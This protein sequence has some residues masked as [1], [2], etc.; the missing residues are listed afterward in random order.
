MNQPE[1]TDSDR[2]IERFENLVHCALRSQVVAGR[3]RVRRIEA[4]G[5]SIVIPESHEDLGQLVEC[6]PDRRSTASRVFQQEPDAGRFRENACLAHATE[7]ADNSANPTIQAIADV[8][9]KMGDDR[10]KL[11]KPR[12]SDFLDQRLDGPFEQRLVGTRQ[13]QQVHRVGDDEL[14]RRTL[15]AV[16][17]RG[18]PI[19][20]DRL[21]PPRRCI[22]GE[23]LERVV[24]E[25]LGLVNRSDEPFCDRQMTTQKRT[26]ESQTAG[27]GPIIEPRPARGNPR[28]VD[29]SPTAR[30]RIGRRD[31]MSYD[32]VIIG[33]GPGGYVCAIRC[34]Q[35]GFKTA[36]VEEAD[37]GG[38]CLNWGCI[39]TKALFSAT[40]LLHQAKTA[41]EMGI[42]FGP[43]KIDL[44][45]LADW[46]ES[47]VSKLTTGVGMLLEKG[48]VDVMRARGRL[49]DSGGVAL[50]TGETVSASRT[51]L[52]TGSLP[53]EIPGFSFDQEAVWS[54]DDALALREI[55]DRLVVIGGGVI[56]LELATI[57]QRLGSAVTVIELLPE[58]LSAVD[59]DRRT[60]S[61]LKRS[62][63][64]QGIA[65]LTNTAAQGWEQTSNGINVRLAGGNIVEGDRILLAVGRRPNSID[66]GLDAAGVEIDP[67]GFVVV[68]ACFET[69]APSIF[70]IGDLV[71]GPML[72]HKASAEGVALAERF[73]GGSPEL[74]VDLIPQAIFTDP[75]I[76][77][78]GLSEARA[79][80]TERAILVGRFP[81]A[82]L[83]KALGM[84][85]GDGFFQIVAD[86][87]S[88]RVLGVQIVGAEASDLIS[89]AAVAI[90]NGLT[91]EALAETVHPHPTL[92][93]GLKEAAENALGRAIH[94]ANR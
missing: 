37:L 55:P 17:E 39:P 58:L 28:P 80:E 86:G 35:L 64:A 48:G 72:A 81:Y 84:R 85:A 65:T 90:R 29:G 20:R 57:Y 91:L 14:D 22:V 60:I 30:Y 77:S 88:H 2:T 74:D 18:G 26:P 43:A 8:R 21:H 4:H 11:Q 10:V 89:E 36:L 45:N 31:A 66:L 73:A 47:V 59:L 71:P 7:C 13:I 38:V 76:A 49:T 40:K 15:H 32:V 41:A 68:D 19:G 5:E 46:K 12:A 67:R 79:K 1:P 34:A 52:A 75:E 51:V 53:V 83:G 3:E 23:D 82:A 63:Q 93:E 62:L 61:T 44:P 92:P 50:S 24:S 16:E 9:P 78:V 33:G 25:G 69:T 94:T 70:A 87:E 56:G 42:S 27:H 6:T 54:S